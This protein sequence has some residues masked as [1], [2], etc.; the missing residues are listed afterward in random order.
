MRGGSAAITDTSKAV[1][2]QAIRV[3]VTGIG[4]LSRFGLGDRNDRGLE[5]DLDRCDDF[6][7]VLTVLTALGPTV[8]LIEGMG[9][10]GQHPVESQS[11][12]IPQIRV[13]D[14]RNAERL[15]PD[16]LGGAPKAGTFCPSSSSPGSPK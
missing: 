1:V 8:G 15:L 9:L 2:R 6:L 10:P 7:A 4:G 3:C 13:L 11:W 16:A 12:R 14:E 5:L